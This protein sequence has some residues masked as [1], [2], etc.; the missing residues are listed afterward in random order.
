MSLTRDRG[1][2]AVLRSVFAPVPGEGRWATVL[3]MDGNIG[4]GGDPARLLRRLHGLLAPRG[5]LLVE[6]HPRSET[7]ELLTVRFSQHGR[8]TG[9]S[10]GWAHV[11]MTALQHFALEPSYGL[12]EEWSVGGRS[13]AS[14]T[15]STRRS[16]SAR[17]AYE[18]AVTTAINA[19]MS[20]R[21]EP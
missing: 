12:D 2:P 20:A 4:I 18:P 17:T 16:R 1:L 9:P 6:T 11:G 19:T 14:L 3:L 21:C 5:R 8:P 10:F 13:F 15:R 7:Y